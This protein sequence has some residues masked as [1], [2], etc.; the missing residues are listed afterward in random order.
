MSLG[1]R[2]RIIKTAG[3]LFAEHGYRGASVRR[4]CDLARANPG[5]VSYH[6][7]GKKQLYR[8]VLRKAAE[9]LAGGTAHEAADG[10][11]TSPPQFADAVARVVD[12]LE[13]S[14]TELR[15]LVRDLAD[16]GGVA[17]EALEPVLR[18]AHHAL[19]T[20][21]DD[22]INDPDATASSKEVFL[23]LAAPLVLLTLAWPVLQRS[24]DLDPDQ[25]R[26]I[27]L[28]ACRRVLDAHGLGVE[29][30]R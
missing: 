3:A 8:T 26:T 2:E 7:G 10:A 4:I 27:L 1:T 22:W 17:V 28:A 14:P 15:L 21:A 20:R 9:S 25:R 30:S 13:Q 6:F 23:D 5:A 24:L 16:G 12:R 19:R 18:A 29:R 11:D